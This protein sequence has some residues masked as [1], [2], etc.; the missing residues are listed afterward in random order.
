MSKFPIIAKTTVL[1]PLPSSGP[2]SPNK[3]PA[4][5]IST[6]FVRKIPTDLDRPLRQNNAASLIFES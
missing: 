4:A 1:T 2:K 3:I 5:P 6:N